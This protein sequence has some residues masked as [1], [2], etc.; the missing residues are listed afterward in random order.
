[1][2]QNVFV[3]HQQHRL[4]MSLRLSEKNSVQVRHSLNHLLPDR[5][6]WDRE[7]TVN[8]DMRMLSQPVYALYVTHSD[9]EW[10]RLD[11]GECPLMVQLGWVQGNRDGRFLVKNEGDKYSLDQI[12]ADIYG[13]EADDGFKKNDKNRKSS[14]KKNKKN[15]KK[16]NLATNLYN[17][18][19]GIILVII[20]THNL[21][22]QKPYKI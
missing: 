22:I 17:E 3:Y 7:I 15:A 1:M 14:K 20:M 12:R 10:R 19:K 11:G 21:Y 2:Q 6:I 16:D 8:L 9:G 4:K 18:V 5:H 13:Q